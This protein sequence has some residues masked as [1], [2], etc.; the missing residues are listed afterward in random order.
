M[1]RSLSRLLLLCAICL[2]LMAQAVASAADKRVALVVGN[3]K[4]RNTPIL[5][6][7]VNDATDV[8]AA[9]TALGF[10][11]TLKLDADKRQMDLAVAQF[12]RDAGDAD[13]AMFYYAGHGMQFEGRNYVMPVDAVLQDEISL[14][15][16]MTAIDDV[17]AALDRSPGV[18]IMVLDSC[19]NNPLAERLVRSIGGGARGAAEARG[20]ALPER[21]RGMII[22]YATQA[23]DVAND[24]SGRNSPFSTAFLKEVREP[25]LEIG[26][27]FRRIG[28]DVYKATNGQQSPEL[29]ISL[30]QEYYLNQGETDQSMWAR[31]RANAT[32]DALRAFIAR[33]PDSFYAPDARERLDRFDRDAANPQAQPRPNDAR[34]TRQPAVQRQQV[35]ALAP[36]TPAVDDAAPIQ[37]AASSNEIRDRLYEL[38]FDPGPL[39]GPYTDATRDAIR[40]F[41]QQ[42]KLPSTGV[43]SMGLLRRLREVGDLKPWGAIV[44][45]K[46]SQKWGMSWGEVTRKAAVARAR[47]SCGDPASCPVEIAFFGAACG[48][49]AHSASNWSIVSRGEVAK[50]KEA[51]LADC[52]KR[53]HACQIVASVCADGSQRSTASK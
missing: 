48:A 4:Y 21:T 39:E 17:R 41:E 37:D 12:A 8:A 46:D 35:A 24:G 26:T 23:G 28:G 11:V 38:N 30:M 33:Y 6:N 42:N 1:G 32:P 10:Q 22:A 14:R 50:A 5:D 53:G 51:A 13:A 2:G 9:L 29:S 45:G 16:E 19:R 34:A 3:S 20:L 43:A 47:V 15:Y 36:P 52:G 18:K 27:M 40:E 25:G 31:V 49:F 7:P 44:Y